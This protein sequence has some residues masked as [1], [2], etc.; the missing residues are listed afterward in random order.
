[1]SLRKI[2]S[3]AK[4]EYIKW[5][6]NPRMIILAV[7]VVFIYNGVASPLI[8]CSLEMDSP[9]NLFEPLL[10]ITNSGIIL[11]LIPAV[12]I[13]LIADF[14]KNDGNTLFVIKRTGRTNYLF[15]QILFVIF[16]LLS[17]LSFVFLISIL[18]VYSYSFVGEQWSTA[19]T[20][21]TKEFPE[22]SGSIILQLLPAHL[23]NNLSL[24]DGLF[25]TFTYLFL[26]IFLLAMV[27][28]L[29]SVI[30]KKRIGFITT[31][32][33]IGLGVAVS[34]TKSSLMWIFPMPHSI[35]WLHFNEYYREE[36]LPLWCSYLYFILLIL[37][38]VVLSFVFLKKANFDG[39]DEID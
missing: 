12:F 34:S 33:I 13:T 30:K 8:Q 26:Y 10:A 27:L 39:V 21:Y 23:Y 38:F 28:M 4:I 24:P 18:Q 20:Q 5:I 11:L 22:K 31:G 32:G 3:I 14:P 7:L 17:F 1:M 35:V 9:L 16:S 25:L 36:I 15:G 37:V 2:F 29:F 19:I 6:S